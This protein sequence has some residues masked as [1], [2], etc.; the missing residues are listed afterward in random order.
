MNQFGGYKPFGMNVSVRASSFTA[1]GATGGSFTFVMDLPQEIMRDGIGCY[2][3]MDSSQRLGIDLTINTSGNLYTTPPTNPGVLTVTPVVYYYTKPADTSA[4][5]MPQETAPVGAGTMQFWRTLNYVLSANANII[6]VQ[7]SGRYVRNILAV[8][9]DASDVRSDTV[10]PTTYRAEL[11]NNLI[12]DAVTI[13]RDSNI[14]RTF[15]IDD[16]TGVIPL[17]IGT[18]DPDGSPG[19]EWGDRWWQTSTASQL[20]LKFNAGATGKLYLLLNEI[21]VVGNIF[22]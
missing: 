5:G 3:N 22:R 17:M 15:G 13:A 4:D 12:D 14:Y 21:E 19:N 18:T 1:S 11:D 16:P 9:T 10:R 2:P 8:F 7:L 20:V 6:T